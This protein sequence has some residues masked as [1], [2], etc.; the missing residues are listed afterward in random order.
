MDHEAILTLQ[1]G[2]GIPNRIWQNVSPADETLQ[3]TSTQQHSPF[4]QEVD[5]ADCVRTRDSGHL[6]LALRSNCGDT[7]VG[8]S[9]E[10]E[11]ERRDGGGELREIQLAREGRRMA[12]E[13][14]RPL[15]W[16]GKKQQQPQSIYTSFASMD[17]VRVCVPVPVPV[18]LPL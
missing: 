3:S 9:Q 15:P 5:E 1:G 6:P 18:G 10:G 11:G 8:S 4:R 17:G 2:R 13:E 16:R 7:V 14:L 12:A